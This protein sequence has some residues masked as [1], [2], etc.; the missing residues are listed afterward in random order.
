MS[1]INYTPADTLAG[2]LK[3]MSPAEAIRMG[4]ALCSAVEEDAGANIFHGSIWPENVTYSGG[5]AALGPICEVNLK[6]MSPEALEYI[7]PE[8]FW[9]GEMSPAADV[10]SI[11][12][13]LFTALN[14]GLMPFFPEKESYTA[15]DRATALQK[16]MRNADLP[17]PKSACRELGDVILT[18]MSFKAEDRYNSVKGLRLALESLPES[19]AIPAAAP[20]IRLKPKEVEAARSY[21]VDKDFEKVS[22]DKPKKVK[23]QQHVD[24]DMDVQEFRR[25]KKKKNW[26]IPLLTVV[27]VAAAFIL[28]LKGCDTEDEPDEPISSSSNTSEPGDPHADA[29]NTPDIIVDFSTPTPV[30]SE[31]P[32]EP[33]EEPQSEPRY[34][35]FVEDVTWEEA[36]ASCEAMGGHLATVENEEQLQTIIA[37]AEEKGASFVW[38][39]AYRGADG[40]WYYVT[41]E[42]MSYFAWD[43]GEPSAQDADGTPEDY[44]LLWY[45]QREGTWT[46]NDMR[47]DPISVIPATYSGKTAYICQFD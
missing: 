34:T 43:E 41:G 32:V 7:A 46:Y 25:P 47:N 30:V 29:T 1:E 24:E 10:Y 22:P 8:Q 26:L 13:I 36:R 20:V 28:V 19:A 37:M 15:E 6:N 21:K 18:A 12:L 45:R 42:K 33:S 39:G 23:R 17:Y 2:K 31:E 27:V 14:G 4:V 11:G 9:N 5:K 38:L 3:S 40:E 35:V 16:R 44:L